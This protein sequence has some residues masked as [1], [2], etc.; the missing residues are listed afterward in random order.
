MTGCDL[1]EE[2]S[3]VRWYAVPFGSCDVPEGGKRGGRQSC[4]NRLGGIDAQMNPLSH[5]LDLGRG[6][7]RYLVHLIIH[8]IPSVVTFSAAQMRSPSFSRLSSS[9]TTTN[10]PLAIARVASSIVSNLNGVG[11]VRSAFGV[12]VGNDIVLY[13]KCTVG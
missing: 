8:A 10:S 5:Q 12:R 2:A 3:T 7:E 6:E 4:S 11:G 1:T 13:V 9:M